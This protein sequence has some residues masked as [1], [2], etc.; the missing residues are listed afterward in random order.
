MDKIAKA[1]SHTALPAVQPAASFAEVG[2]GR[3]LAVDGA[4]GIPA[5]VQRVAGFLRAVF[6]FETCVDVADEIC[7]WFLLAIC[8]II[9]EG[10]HTVI[11][12]ITH[13]HLLNLPKLAHL[14][15]EILIESI[16][17]V[18]QL[19]RIHLVLRIVCW[20]LVQVGQEDGL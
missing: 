20:V 10:R 19:A 1:S 14:A 7:F 6:V 16:E 17:M 12:I 13:N 2:D 9:G 3:E 4:R 18:L 8:V 15:P 11:V 5:R